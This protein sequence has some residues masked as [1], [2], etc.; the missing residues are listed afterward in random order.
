VIS[1]MARRH[2]SEP[3]RTTTSGGP[4]KVFSRQDAAWIHVRARSVKTALSSA[5]FEWRAQR[6]ASSA[7]CRNVSAL[8]MT[9]SRLSAIAFD[10]PAFCTSEPKSV[11][12]RRTA[13]GQNR[14]VWPSLPIINLT[15]S[16]KE[17]WP[18]IEPRRVSAA[19]YEQFRSAT[20]QNPAQSFCRTTERLVAR[21]L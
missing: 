5:V 3:Y 12:Y 16:F 11:P 20:I 2:Q 18:S 19:R 15:V 10:L 1:S 9:L 21:C 8:D 17:A 4:T 7:Y 6:I 14:S 13:S